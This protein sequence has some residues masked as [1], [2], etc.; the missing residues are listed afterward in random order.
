M[1]KMIWVGMM[2]AVMAAPVYAQCAKGSQ[3]LFSCMTKKGKQIEVCD[4]GA[5][6]SYRFGPPAAPEIAIQV[7]RQQA[8]TFQW[9]GMGRYMSYS[10][11]IPN[12]QTVY[13]VFTSLDRISEKHA[14]EA[15]VN[16]LQ[17]GELLATVKCSGAPTENRLEGV[18]LPAND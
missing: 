13:S 1:K 17:K 16:V 3:A 12:G 9:A 8:R 18:D 6:I 10:V 7:P 5:T 14:F 15:G 2:C 11:D 4:A